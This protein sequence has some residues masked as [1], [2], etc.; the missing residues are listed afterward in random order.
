MKYVATT[1]PNPINAK[2]P[3]LKNKFMANEIVALAHSPKNAN[4]FHKKRR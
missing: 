3:K 2:T 1:A 4:F